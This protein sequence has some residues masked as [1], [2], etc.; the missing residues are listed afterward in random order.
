MTYKKGVAVALTAMVVSFYFS[1]TYVFKI[2]PPKE[3]V[4]KQIVINQPEI[5]SNK[6]L[7]KV[8]RIS[9]KDLTCLSD[10]AYHE[11]RG[12]GRKGIAAVIHVTLNRKDHPDFPKRVC[13]V[14]YQKVNGSCQYAWVCDNSKQ[15]V[16]FRRSKEY[17]HIKNIAK[18]IATNPDRVR[19]DPTRGS[20]YYKRIDEPSSFFKRR[21]IAKAT[22]GQ[23]KF[24]KD[25]KNI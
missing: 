10:M 12:E 2:D 23:H 7:V 5:I 3:Q 6:P 11:A 18:T 13:G 1:K 17:Q 24:Y 22:I 4:Q 9:E 21:L 14:V 8:I 25:A 16:A 20:I 19:F 15:N